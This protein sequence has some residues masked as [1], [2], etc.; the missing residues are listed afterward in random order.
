[1]ATG[2]MSSGGGAGVSAKISVRGLALKRRE[3]RRIGQEKSSENLSQFCARQ[4][5][6][7]GYYSR[8][9]TRP[10]PNLLFNKISYL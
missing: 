8:I 10:M 5:C 9:G 1:M 3:T 2:V 4:Q 6:G 7:Q